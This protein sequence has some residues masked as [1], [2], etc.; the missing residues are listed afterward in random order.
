MI[1][2]RER[3]TDVAAARA[4][5]TLAFEQTDG[6]EPAE[7]RLVDDLR[8]CDEWLPALSWIGELD[9]AVVGHAVG[10]RGHVGD[11]PCVGVGPVGVAPPRQRA[12]I[13]SALMHAL[14]GA[15]DASNE[16]LLCLLGDPG[17]YSRFGFVPSTELGLDAPDP[18]WGE[19]FQALALSAWSPAICGRFRYA[20]PF[21]T[22]S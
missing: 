18:S 1:V 16:P 11:I 10:S 19:Y 13:G 7:A 21:D 20:A 12:G 4:V 17:Y 3:S 2:R 14:I 15:A 8:R 9:G 22:V 6:V 5:H